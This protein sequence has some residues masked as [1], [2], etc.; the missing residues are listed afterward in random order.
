MNNARINRGIIKKIAS[1]L[2][3]LN[4]RVIYVGGAIV[5]LYIDDPAADD[6]RPTKNVDISVS[7]AT[8]AELEKIREGLTKKG[9]I[10]TAEDDVT[11]RFRYEDVKVYVMNTRD[12]GWAPAN[13]WF[14]PGFENR[15]RIEIENQYIFIIPFPYFFSDQICRL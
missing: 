3:E 14:A 11:C 9:F 7:V 4:E 2:G 10:Q 12:I 5:G 6:V 15:L 1:A 8:I 13:P